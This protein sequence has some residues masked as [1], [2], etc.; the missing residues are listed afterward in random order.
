MQNCKNHD[1]D[2]HFSIPARWVCPPAALDAAAAVGPS[3]LKPRPQNLGS[4]AQTCFGA[5]KQTL[6]GRLSFGEKSQFLVPFSCEY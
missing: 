2:R 4:K 6:E 3:T 1:L 5:M